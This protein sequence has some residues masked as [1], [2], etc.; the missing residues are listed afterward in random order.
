SAVV[1]ES[2]L[3][4]T[5]SEARTASAWA[6]W[7]VRSSG[8]R[9]RATRHASSSSARATM[10]TRM[11]FVAPAGSSPAPAASE[12]GGEPTG[13]GTGGRG[14]REGDGGGGGGGGGPRRRRRADPDPGHERRCQRRRQPQPLDPIELAGKRHRLPTEQ[15]LDDRR[16]FAEAVVTAVVRR[17]VTE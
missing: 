13:R 17:V 11:A 14:R 6:I 2:V 1:A 4:Q 10:P 3:C 8:N 5:E 12:A 9:A 16:V 15:P 7:P